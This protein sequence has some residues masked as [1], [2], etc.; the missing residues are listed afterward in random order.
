ML[1]RLFASR[2]E[3]QG[4]RD[5]CFM[6]QLEPLEDRLTPSSLPPLNQPLLTAFQFSYIQ[7]SQQNTGNPGA[8]SGLVLSEVVVTLDQIYTLLNPLL[9]VN[10][11]TLSANLA[12]A[13]NAITANPAHNTT[14]GAMTGQLA[15]SLTLSAFLTGDMSDMSSNAP[16]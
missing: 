12:N 15:Q 3:R 8:L 10:N 11:P 5:T 16:T 7:A 9:G 1:M 2:R 13:Q 14:F 4:N 6:P